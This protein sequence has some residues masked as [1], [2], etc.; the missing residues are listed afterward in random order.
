MW[1]NRP[2]E[3]SG[4]FLKVKCCVS[5]SAPH[6]DAGTCQNSPVG[7]F[8]DV[9]GSRRIRAASL[10]KLEANKRHV[11]G[12]DALSSSFN[13]SPLPCGPNCIHHILPC[14]ELRFRT[15]WTC[16]LLTQPPRRSCNAAALCPG[17]ASLFFQHAKATSGIHF[18]FL[19]RFMVFRYD[20]GPM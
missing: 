19:N 15:N 18:L 4:M 6:R 7:T 11:C 3:F 5:S 14:N 12:F 10:V 16:G 9:T 2:E 17:T 20:G 13:I 8:T 1:E